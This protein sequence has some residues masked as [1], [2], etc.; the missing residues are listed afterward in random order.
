MSEQALPDRRDRREVDEVGDD[1]HDRGG[2]EH[3][4]V[5]AEPRVTP[6]EGRE[7]AGLGEHRGEP[8]RGVE[9][10]DDRGCGREH[11]GDRHDREAGVA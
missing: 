11:R 7:L 1:E 10:G 3:P 8:A 4:R 5:R 6:E 9:R 2:D